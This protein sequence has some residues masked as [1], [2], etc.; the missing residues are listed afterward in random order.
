MPVAPSGMPDSGR[1][2]D[3]RRGA[4]PGDGEDVAL[5][6]KERSGGEHDHGGEGL[7]RQV[8]AKLGAWSTPGSSGSFCRGQEKVGLRYDRLRFGVAAMQRSLPIFPAACL[9]VML[10]AFQARGQGGLGGFV[11]GAQGTGQ[12]DCITPA[13]RQ[14]IRAQVDA[15]RRASRARG[16]GATDVPVLASGRE[17]LPGP[18][19]RIVRRPRSDARDPRLELQLLHARRASRIGCGAPQLRRAGDRRPGVRGPGWRG[20]R[21]ARRRARHEHESSG[22]SRTT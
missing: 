4:G 15:F 18:L 10:A 5:G 13:E 22:S 12:D 11:A 19:H 16:P 14:L 17:P 21:H 20:R 8:L 7:H 1:G 6:G 3:Q 9:V 2:V